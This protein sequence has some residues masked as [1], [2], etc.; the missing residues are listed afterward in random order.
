M[1]NKLKNFCKLFKKYWR[2]SVK[3]LGFSKIQLQGFSLIEIALALM[4]LGIIA[5][6]IFNGLDL[7]ESAKIRSLMTDLRTYHM[8]LL[9][10]RSIYGYWPGDDPQARTRF[11]EM[12]SGYTTPILNGDGDG[13][14]NSEGD[15]SLI[16]VHCAAAGLLLHPRPPSSKFGGCFSVH[17]E[18]GEHWLR[19]GQGRNG[20]QGLLTPKQIQLLK[21]K[22]E[23]EDPSSGVIR[24]QSG[25]G[26]SPTACVTADN[27]FNL[28]NK[29][30]SCVLQ[31]ALR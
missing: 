7:L 9:E 6:T 5:G 25:A 16:W 3:R 8:V 18:G 22:A 10:Y 1:Q 4:I 21:I 19:V 30:P 13:E 28:E 27:R 29:K 20:S 11:G 26:L 24:V 15:R 31:M 23:E 2:S 14:I 17:Y 12:V